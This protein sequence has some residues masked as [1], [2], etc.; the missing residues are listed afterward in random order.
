MS[1]R[2]P[3]FREHVAI[4]AVS[5]AVLLFQI[6]L[7]RVL[8][9]VVWYHF[10]FLT[11]SL[12]M[13]GL[14][15]PGIWLSLVPRPQK[16]L[17]PSLIAAGI[18]VPLATAYVVQGGALAL[19][20]SIG[21]VVLAVLPALLALGCAV[22]VLLMR[23]TGPDIGRMYGA[24]LAGAF[25]G[26]CLAIP[27][28]HGLPTPI[29]AAGCGLLP[30]GAAVLL[31]GWWR[32]PAV[33]LMAVLAGAMGGSDLFQ[34]THS[35]AYDETVLPPLAEVWTP[36]A[37]LTVFSGDYFQLAKHEA[38]FAWGRGTRAPADQAPE[39][40][41][42]EQ[43]GHAGTPITHYTGDLEAVEHLL[44]DVTTLGHQLRPPQS[45]AVIG[46]GGGRDVLSALLTGATTIDAI[47]LNPG[48]I[49][50]VSER[51][52]DFSGDI[53]HQPGVT[54]VAREG[55][56]HLT[57]SPRSFD[58]VQLSLIDSWAASA[59]GAFALA[60]NNLYTLEA[61]QLYLDRLTRKGVLATSRWES[62]LPRLLI[63]ARASLEARGHPRPEEHLVV[64]SAQELVTVLITEAPWSSEE[65]VQLDT[66]CDTRGFERRYPTPPGQGGWVVDLAEGRTNALASAGLN[67]RPPTDDSPYFF[68]VRSPFAR[69]VPD[70]SLAGLPMNS[71]STEI[72]RQLM[73]RVLLLSVL[74]FGLPFVLPQ[75]RRALDDGSPALGGSVFFSAIGAGFLLW[76]SLL[77]Q[78]F[79][80]LLG[81]PSTAV[82]VVLASLLAG[83]GIGSALSARV[84]LDRLQ[85]IG[86]TVPL[87][88]VL[89][90]AVLPSL[91]QLLLPVHLAVRIAL[92][93]GLLAAGGAVLGLWFPLGM[94]RFGERRKPWH[95]ALNGA[96]GVLAAVMSLALSMAWGFATVGWIAAGC[97]G[98]AWVALRGAKTG[99]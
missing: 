49:E 68:Q 80:L 57:H 7:T 27:L 84:G 86:W 94:V 4:F 42:L 28:M 82:S 38:G 39:Q 97:Y 72:L 48:T 31:G 37:R 54:A 2:P 85:R 12:V 58:L 75:L 23:A 74:L 95:W 13:L 15:V 64:V 96:F 62:E 66:I 59:A 60:E 90:V 22:C 93:A 99:H 10:A 43:D 56:S 61:F 45:V 11:I 5:A 34:V 44:Y 88:L 69:V 40:L 73:R 53:Y 63:L 16:W 9:V 76:E 87:L 79:V 14:G 17:G 33:G 32:W 35:K 91:I 98:V 46:A 21:L 19:Q 26:A 8:S 1:A 41:W 36:T 77:I 83:M 6:A 47:E 50:L 55:R 65:L 30:L 52:G 3:S 20:S 25:V 24:D 70:A 29:L 92:S 81:H 51:F 89:V 78:H 67:L 18:G 71:E